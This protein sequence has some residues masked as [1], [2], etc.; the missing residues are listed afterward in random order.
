MRFQSDHCA[1]ENRSR[2]K[3]RPA[4]KTPYRF[5]AAGLKCNPHKNSKLKFIRRGVLVWPGRWTAVEG[6]E[7]R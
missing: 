5:R 6:I 4:V 3:Y 1:Q 2:K 7:G